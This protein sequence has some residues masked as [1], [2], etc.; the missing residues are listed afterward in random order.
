MAVEQKE[1]GTQVAQQWPAESVGDHTGA[2][3][4]GGD[5]K[6]RAAG[7]QVVGHRLD[8]GAV[9]MPL[10]QHQQTPGQLVGVAEPA[11]A[12]GP[13]AAGR[14]EV[15]PLSLLEQGAKDAR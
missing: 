9:A 5:V 10:A 6:G 12:V 1:T 11:D 3:Y 2:A 15:P 4:P 7:Q 14:D 8:A 13:A